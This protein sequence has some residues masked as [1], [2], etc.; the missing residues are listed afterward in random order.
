MILAGDVGGTKTLLALFEEQ[1][2]RLYRAAERTYASREHG[3]LDE[4]IR[5][6]VAEQQQPIERAT[7]GIAG[8]VD[9]GRVEATNLPWIVDASVVAGEVGLGQVTLI[10]DLEANAYGIPALRPE[11]LVTLQ[12]GADLPG[13]QAIIAAGTGLG[14]A[15]LYWDGRSHRPFACEGG[16]ADFAPADALQGELVQWLRARWEHV[17]GGHVSWERVLSGPGLHNLYLFLRDSGRGEEPAWLTEEMRDRD[18]APIISRAALA[19]RSSLCEQALSLFVSLYGAE[20]G[21]LGLKMLATG[22]LYVGGGI[23]PKILPKLA[24]GTFVRAFNAKG[25]IR[26]VTEMIPVRVIVNDR[27]ALLGAARQAMLAD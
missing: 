19:G 5:R 24:D 13:N 1:H 2:G 17:S 16:H 10:N 20:A 27:T 21:N 26:P 4:I 11:D 25:R 6:F 8:P 23:A 15:G 9:C 22:G 14:E 12:A 7:L 3:G 18:P